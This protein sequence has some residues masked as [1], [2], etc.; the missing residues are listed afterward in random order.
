[1]PLLCYDRLSCLSIC[2]IV[3]ILELNGR[4]N[5]RLSFG[6]DHTCSITSTGDMY[7]W[8]NNQ[9]GQLGHINDAVTVW[10]PRLLE[11]Y[12][13]YFSEVSCG[14]GFTVA[15]TRNSFTSP[16]TPSVLFRSVSSY[17]HLSMYGH[18]RTDQPITN[19]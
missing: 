11:K 18:Q 16:S 13:E 5:T 9:H 10:S 19:R 4:D 8:G 17:C 12:T 15:I 14:H 2:Q 3:Q 6:Y 1:M 7:T